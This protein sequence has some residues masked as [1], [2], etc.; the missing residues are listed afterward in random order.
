MQGVGA[1]TIAVDITYEPR[2]SDWRALHE[3]AGCPSANGLGMLAH[4]AALQMRWWW[5]LPVDAAKLLEVIS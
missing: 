1:H 4:Q 3:R 5:D 2:M